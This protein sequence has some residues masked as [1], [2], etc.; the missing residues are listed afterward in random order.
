MRSRA[1]C[2]HA[3]ALALAGCTLLC[4]RLTPRDAPVPGMHVA[5]EWRPPLRRF[6]LRAPPRVHPPGQML[7][8]TTAAPLCHSAYL[9]C[10][11]LPPVHSPCIL[12]SAQ[13]CRYRS[14][15]SVKEVLKREYPKGVDLVYE[16]V[17]GD[18]FETCL[19][20]LAVGGRLVVI[21]MMSQVGC[22]WIAAGLLVQ[23]TCG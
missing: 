7:S 22:A 11:A 3:V 21:G 10:P 12:L 9:P 15:E 18:M 4:L 16:S 6:C 8:R 5:R 14:E 2:K 17:G 19:N 20:A 13:A 1:A 23:A